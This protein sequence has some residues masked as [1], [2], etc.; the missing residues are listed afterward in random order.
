[1]KLDCFSARDSGSLQSPTGKGLEV[2]H[3]FQTQLSLLAHFLPQLGIWITQQLSHGKPHLDHLQPT[4]M[5][6]HRMPCL[7]WDRTS[8]KPSPVLGGQYFI[9]SRRYR[10]CWSWCWREF[11]I[12]VK[13]VTTSETFSR[14]NYECNRNGSCDFDCLWSTGA[15]CRLPHS[16]YNFLCFQ[17]FWGL[18][19][20][21]GCRMQCRKQR[22]RERGVT[23]NFYLHCWDSRKPLSWRKANCCCD[24]IEALYINTVPAQEW[25]ERQQQIQ[26]MK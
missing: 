10:S 7:S 11:A 15:C 23:C 20:A 3:I 25:D 19:C 17:H 12:M 18:V 1:M 2:T 6:S 21:G 22:C 16:S 14:V 4:R 26:L 24:V 9:K 5:L 8:V 13:P